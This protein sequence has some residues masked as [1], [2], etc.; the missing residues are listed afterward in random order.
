MQFA[1]EPD[2]D[3]RH[4]DIDILLTTK[5][6]GR[7]LGTDAMRTIVR[8]LIEQ[9]GHHRLTLWTRPHHARAIHVYEK[10]G[11]RQVG[12]TRLS[13]RAFRE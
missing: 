12:I 10:V 1:E 5:A 2:E 3:S 11:F 13:E 4:A 8:Y 6:Q 9:R 7:G